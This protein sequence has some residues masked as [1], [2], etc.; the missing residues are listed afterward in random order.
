MA[1]VGMLTAM[2]VVLSRLVAVP[3]GLTLRISAGPVPVILSGLWLGPLAGGITGAAGDLIGC[4]LNGYA[5]NPLITVSSVLTGVIPALFVRFIF[6][7]RRF[8]VRFLRLFAV[9]ACTMMITS[10]GFSVLGLS[11]M[12]GLPFRAT[13][14]SRLPQTAFLCVMN[15]FL[16]CLI[17]SKVRLPGLTAPKPERGREGGDGSR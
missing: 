2:N 14:L 12:Y 5:P 17:Y 6:R 11:V 9:L 4:A 13:W 10:Q 8:Y 16:V 7:D 1:Y 15:S 3:V